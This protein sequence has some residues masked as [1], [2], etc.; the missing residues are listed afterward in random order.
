MVKLWAISKIIRWIVKVW[1]GYPVEE[2]VMCG[3]IKR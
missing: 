2:C 3:R 1:G